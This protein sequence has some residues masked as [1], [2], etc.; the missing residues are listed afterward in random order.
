[1][2]TLAIS[3]KKTLLAT[4]LSPA[5]RNACATRRA[6]STA[7]CPAASTAGL[8]SKF[9]VKYK[10]LVLAPTGACYVVLAVN[11]PSAGLKHLGK[12]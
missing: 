5:A 12:G 2:T 3:A 9:R 11:F 7:T 10:S 8:A 4:T 1:M 6:R